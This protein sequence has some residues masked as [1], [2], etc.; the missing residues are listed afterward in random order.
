MLLL[1]NV[2]VRTRAKLLMRLASEALAM[3]N[4]LSLLKRKL[5]EVIFWRILKSAPNGKRPRNGGFSL[6]HGTGRPDSVG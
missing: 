2:Q 4:I 1:A 3:N 5:H 6:F